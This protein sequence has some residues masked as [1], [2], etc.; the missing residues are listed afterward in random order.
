MG[1]LLDHADAPGTDLSD[2]DT[3]SED[4]SDE[5]LLEDLDDTA[6]ALVSAPTSPPGPHSVLGSGLR[7][8][9]VACRAHRDA[10]AGRASCGS[11]STDPV[12][13]PGHGR[14]CSM[15]ESCCNAPPVDGAP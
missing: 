8:C 13:I 4:G 5:E 7:V 12:P 6:Y 14:L 11:V 15:R 10:E 9:S 1:W 2:P 3:G